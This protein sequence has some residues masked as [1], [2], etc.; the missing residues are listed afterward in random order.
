MSWRLV[1]SEGRWYRGKHARPPG[2]QVQ[3]A[4]FLLW[5]DVLSYVPGASCR[6]GKGIT[7]ADSAGKKSKAQTDA[8][9]VKAEKLVADLADRDDFSQWYQHLVYKTELAD[10]SPV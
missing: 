10:E 4:G 9:S 6:Q 5:C 1:A 7:V 8:K 2:I 3:R